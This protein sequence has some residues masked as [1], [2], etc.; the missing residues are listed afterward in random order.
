M[1]IPKDYQEIVEALA[2]ATNEGRVKWSASQF[3][4]TVTVSGAKFRL[5]SDMQENGQRYVTF[6][7][8]DSN[9]RGLDGWHVNEGD[10]AYDHMQLLFSTARRQAL[11]V[12]QRLARLLN[13]IRT[14]PVIGDTGRRPRISSIRNSHISFPGADDISP[15]RHARPVRL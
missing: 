13:E 5:S 11:D 10:A 2:I 6:T 8:L 15:I 12:P 9:G 14:S 3:D 1:A 7:L 4:V